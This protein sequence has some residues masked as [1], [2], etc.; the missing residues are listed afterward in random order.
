MET[1]LV[2]TIDGPRLCSGR[3]R[4]THRGTVHARSGAQKG[5]TM[6]DTSKDES[7]RAAREA[8]DAIVS[9]SRGAGSG[10][11][12]EAMRR[13]LSSETYDQLRKRH[14]EMAEDAG[15]RRDQQ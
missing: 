13:Y 7:A 4:L 1:M 5:R 12:A 9:R 3:I 2:P 10:A 11:I 15:P 8:Q 6:S 14:A